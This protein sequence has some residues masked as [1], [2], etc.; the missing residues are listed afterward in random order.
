MKRKTTVLMMTL[1]ILSVTAFPQKKF[2]AGITAGTGF[3]DFR[4]L[5]A[6]YLANDI[7]NVCQRHSK[8][9]FQLN[10]PEEISQLLQ[11]LS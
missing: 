4:G 11:G 8:L 9:I 2:D 3:A 7:S 6:E 1:L 10:P 5:D